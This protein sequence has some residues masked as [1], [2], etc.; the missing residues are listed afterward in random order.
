MTIPTTTPSAP[1]IP[2]TPELRAAYETLYDNYESAIEN[3]TDVGALEALNDSQNDVSDILEKDD[4]Y[5]LA[6]NATLYD[7]LLQHINTTN[8][9]LKALKTKLLAISNGI[10]IFGDV[11][12]AIDKVLTLIPGA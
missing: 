9:D 6:A 10:S 2:L 3:T 11:L 1:T 8:V 5:R 12:G 4:E 7:A